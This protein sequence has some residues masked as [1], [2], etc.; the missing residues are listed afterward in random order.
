MSF[1]RQSYCREVPPPPKAPVWV[2]W[3]I[4]KMVGKTGVSVEAEYYLH[5][6]RVSLNI[7][8]FHSVRGTVLTYGK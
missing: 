5:S 6:D 3:G 2:R 8:K 4:A 7:L 1:H